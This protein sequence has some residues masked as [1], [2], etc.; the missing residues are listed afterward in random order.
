MLA[1]KRGVIW[2]VGRG[3]HLWRLEGKLLLADPQLWD[4]SG[5]GCGEEEVSAAKMHGDVGQGLR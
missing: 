3:K 2:Q 4:P 1:V 5:E